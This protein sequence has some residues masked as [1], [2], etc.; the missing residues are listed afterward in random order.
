MNKST[1]PPLLATAVSIDGDFAPP[2]PAYA[3]SL[4]G[5]HYADLVA[6]ARIDEEGARRYLR[7]HSWPAGL[8]EALLRGLQR[9]P[10]RFMLVDDSGSMA[11][12]DG[13]RVVS[14]GTRSATTTCSRWTE[15]GDSIAFFAGLAAAAHAAT[16]FRFLNR[17]EPL[18]VGANTPDADSNLRRLLTALQQP[19]GGGTPLCFH[20]AEVV[21]RVRSVEHVLRRSGQRAVV[22]IATDGEPS[23][24]DMAVAMK[25]LERLPVWVVVRLCTDSDAVTAY[26]NN[27]DAD[28]ELELDVLDDLAGEAEEVAG[29][30]P[31]LTYAQP[32]HRL[33]EFG[34]PLKELDLLDERR[35]GVEDLRALLA[36]M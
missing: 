13:H 22:V 8:Q 11:I 28:L 30:N 17:E 34:V 5:G 20:I 26:W 1:P 6:G 23:D 16:E 3:A 24:G 33:R 19:P 14:V 7:A 12:E 31:W 18:L 36:D 10:L 29:S 21:E 15:L 25:A 4:P 35:L 32:L 2:L 27:I 9:V